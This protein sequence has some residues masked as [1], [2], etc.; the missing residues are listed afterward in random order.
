[1]TEDGE[2]KGRAQGGDAG[3]RRCRWCGAALEIA[4]NGRCPLDCPACAEVR[5]AAYQR[6]HHR[7][8]GVVT[9][10]MLAVEMKAALAAARTEQRFRPSGRRAWCL[11]CG[12]ERAVDA[13]GYCKECV[14]E[15]LDAVHEAT[16][17]TNGWD[18]P[19][20]GAAVAAGGWRGRPVA[21]PPR[22]RTDCAGV[23]PLR[24]GWSFK[25]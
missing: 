15:R 4:E 25:S 18:R 19:P 21:G 1:M 12:R 23:L 14:R 6:L 13:R 2:A 3:A 10:A 11:F 9:P 17:R 16:G 20:R 7:F 24:A 22:L 5:K 8:G